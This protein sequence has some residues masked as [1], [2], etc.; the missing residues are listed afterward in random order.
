MQKQENGERGRVLIQY[1]REE[2]KERQRGQPLQ[3]KGTRRLQGRFLQE[4]KLIR[5][6]AYVDFLREDW[7]CQKFFIAIGDESKE[8]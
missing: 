5:H 7:N 8:S 4:M 1:K 3:T 6:L 2:G